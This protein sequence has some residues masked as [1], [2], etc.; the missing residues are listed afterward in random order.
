MSAE[1][2]IRL[3]GSTIAEVA[4]RAA[5]ETP[6]VRGDFDHLLR[7]VELVR[8][9]TSLPHGEKI[10][11]E[12]RDLV[13]RVKITVDSRS[14]SFFEVAR[15]VQRNVFEAL[16]LRLGLSPQRVDVEVEGVDW[17]ELRERG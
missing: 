9:D 5:S 15:L 6:G 1:G 11:L 3:S 13:V 12:T 17:S 14:P 7:G 16:R 8:G 10:P 2:L 4:A